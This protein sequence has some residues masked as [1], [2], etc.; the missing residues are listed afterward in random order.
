MF[1]LYDLN[2]QGEQIHTLKKFDPNGEQTLLAHPA[3]FS[4]DDK[5]SQ[6][7]MTIKRHSKVLRTQQPLPIL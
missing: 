4:P 5:Y 6:H 7:W 3:R 1:L 2:E